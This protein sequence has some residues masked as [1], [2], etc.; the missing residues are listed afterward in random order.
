M[1]DEWMRALMVL[2]SEKNMATYHTD[3]IID[4]VASLN[5]RLEQQL[6]YV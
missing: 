5:G 6:L 3:D 1:C 4:S 2:A